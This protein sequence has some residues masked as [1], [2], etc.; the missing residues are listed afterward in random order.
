MNVIL[1]TVTERTHGIGIRRALGAESGSIVRLLLRQLFLPMG[2]GMVVGTIAASAVA[3][4]LEGEPFY[5]PSMDITTLSCALGLFVLAV[6]FA[7]LSP[8]CRALRIDPLPALKH[9]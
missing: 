2:L 3:R 7:L 4:V 6:A 9:E 8:V 1:P 5:L